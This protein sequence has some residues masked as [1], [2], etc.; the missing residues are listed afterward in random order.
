MTEDM[1]EYHALVAELG[2]TPYDACAAMFGH[3]V[4]A[5]IYT[6]RDEGV[7]LRCSGP[8]APGG[9]TWLVHYGARSVVIVAG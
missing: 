6:W 9:K 1:R 2:L 5:V 3:C 8:Q 7:P 4:S